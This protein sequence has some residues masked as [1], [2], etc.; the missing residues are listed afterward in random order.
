MLDP[1]LNKVAGLKSYQYKKTL[2][3][4][5]SKTGQQEF[6]QTT[7]VQGCCIYK[8]RK[9]KCPA[10]T[11]MFRKVSN[12]ICKVYLLISVKELKHFTYSFKKATNLGKLYLYIS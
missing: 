8:M 11:K 4:T 5:F 6:N 9:K 12:N 7:S 2:T 1:L 3:L 10:K